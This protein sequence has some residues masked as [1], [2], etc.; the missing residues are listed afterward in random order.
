[1]PFSA[2]RAGF[3]RRDTPQQLECEG[4]QQQPRRFHRHFSPTGGTAPLAGQSARRDLRSSSEF[5][6][7]AGAAGF[8]PPHGAPHASASCRVDASS[9]SPHPLALQQRPVRQAGGCSLL[10]VYPNALRASIE[11]PDAPEWR[12]VNSIGY[13]PCQ[14]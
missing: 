6:R 11:D 3:R 5:L 1:M 4:L 8:G 13:G 9:D 14:V 12:T 10:R 7:V 2:P